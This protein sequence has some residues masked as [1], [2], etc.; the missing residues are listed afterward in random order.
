[1]LGIEEILKIPP[2]LRNMDTEIE[3][4]GVLEVRN[5]LCSSIEHRVLRRKSRHELREFI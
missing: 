5:N 4:V 3:D 2:T 1:M